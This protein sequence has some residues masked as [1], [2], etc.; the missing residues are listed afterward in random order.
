MAPKR[1]RSTATFSATHVL[2]HVKAAETL[3]RNVGEAGREVVST[4]QSAEVARLIGTAQLSTT[5]LAYISDAVSTVGFSEKDSKRVQD[6]I[7]QRFQL[8]DDA[9]G[10]TPYQNYE[11]IGAFL[12][13]YVWDAISG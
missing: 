9:T 3:L 5:E 4:A 12:P 11:S 7:A 10:G 13:K 1:T 6:A 2:H 8:A